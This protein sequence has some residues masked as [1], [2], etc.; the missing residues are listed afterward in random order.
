MKTAAWCMT[1]PSSCTYM[2]VRVYSWA[3]GDGRVSRKAR[4]NKD[5]EQGWA[6]RQEGR[7]TRSNKDVEQGWAG[8]GRRAGD[9]E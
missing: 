2:Y 6:G 7:K 3:A 1:V 4:S 5:I 8:D 9:K